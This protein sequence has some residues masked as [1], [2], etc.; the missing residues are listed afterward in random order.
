MRAFTSESPLFSS[1]AYSNEHSLDLPPAI[2]IAHFTP[3]SP[4]STMCA[5]PFLTPHCDT[6]FA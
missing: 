2:L 3:H 1:F 4:Y 5:V 6:V